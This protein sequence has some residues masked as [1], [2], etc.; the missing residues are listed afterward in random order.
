MYVGGSHTRDRVLKSAKTNIFWGLKN[1]QTTLCTH[2][3]TWDPRIIYYYYYYKRLDHRG[4]R[5]APPRWHHGDI[6]LSLH[7]I[8]YDCATCTS[9]R[10]MLCV[11]TCALRQR[12]NTEQSLTLSLS[13]SLSFFFY[14]FRVSHADFKPVLSF[15]SKNSN[16]TFS[17]TTQNFFLK[18]F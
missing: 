15:A 5:W 12:P 14:S 7:Q 13:L 17:F 10:S 16:V 3:H 9:P 6:A 11:Y 2:K 1:F 18:K 8:R 4:H